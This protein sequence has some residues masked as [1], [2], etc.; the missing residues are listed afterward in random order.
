MA[1]T[2]APWRNLPDFYGNWHRVY[3][4]YDRWSRKGVWLKPMASLCG[5]A[6]L[7]VGCLGRLLVARRQDRMA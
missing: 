1:R 6:D 2:G 5:D 4:H 7:V 3:V